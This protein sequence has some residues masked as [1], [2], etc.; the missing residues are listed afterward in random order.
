V[1]VALSEV[2]CPSIFLDMRD[3]PIVPSRSQLVRKTE[4]AFNSL[5]RKWLSPLLDALKRVKGVS[6]VGGS[7]TFTWG[8]KGVDFAE[9]FDKIDAWAKTHKTRF[10]IA[11]DE[12]QLVRGDKSLP[13]LFARIADKNRN[14]IIVLTGSEVGLLCDFLGFDNPDSPLYGRHYVEIKMH[15]FKERESKAFLKEG[16]KQISV[17]CSNEI[18]DY[19]VER[20]DGV[21]GWL[22]LFGVRCR[23]KK[24]CSKNAV[25]DA[26][27]EGGK[28]A[29]KEALGIVRFSPRYGIILNFLSTV[30][31]ASWTN[32]KASIEVREKRSLPS[33]SFSELLNKLVKTSLV[34]KEDG[35]YRIADR[36]LIQGIKKEPFKE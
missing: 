16:F 5:G 3:L 28:L 4:T 35:E 14:I 24:E 30:E 11:F 27:D 29:R 12:I 34:E 1:E 8:K 31:K 36:L 17:P 22:T 32:I 20:L 18:V 23:D 6:V 25:D 13:K 7:V 26:L 9:L 19:A 33:S 21:A 10:L 2:D 15:N